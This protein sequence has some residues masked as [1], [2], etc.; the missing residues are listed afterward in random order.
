MG[1]M[2]ILVTGA[3]GQLGREFQEVLSLGRSQIG[4]IP[5]AYAG[6]ELVCAG[7]DRLDIADA[8]AVAEFVDGAGFDLILNCA[9]FT[10]VDACESARDAAFRINETGPRVLA[11]AAHA[12]GCRLVH[13]STD[14]VFS[15]DEPGERVESDPTGPRTVYGESKLAGERA[16]AAACPES[17]VLRTSWLYGAHGGNFVKTVLRLARGRGA[18]KV[19]DDQRGNPTCA[20]DLVHEALVLAATDAYG[21]YHCT[22]EGVCTWYELACAAVEEAGLPCA[23]EPCTTDEFPRPARRPANSALRN[24]RL[25]EGPGDQ[26][27]P[28]RVALRA[29]LDALD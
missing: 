21:L 12:N 1:R 17:F 23:V 14:Y 3:N 19:V 18:L 26:M 11:T 29:Y 24:L 8:Q 27:R 15:G 25:E 4:P 2:K 5:C 10:D 28:W 13:I 6:A 22:G 16:V 20:N 9:A 7:R